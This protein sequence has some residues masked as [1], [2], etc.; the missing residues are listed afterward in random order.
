MA[1]LIQA[2]DLVL[3]ERVGPDHVRFG[4]VILFGRGEEKVIHRVVGRR[5]RQGG[6]VFFQKGDLHAPLGLV[7]APEVLGRVSAVQ[8]SGIAVD[9]TSG[10]GRVVQLGLAC[11]SVGVW[12]TKRAVGGVLAVLGLPYHHLRLGLALDGLVTAVQNRMV[13]TLGL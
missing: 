9:I 1:P 11:T 8:K 10:W 12:R 4:D 13:R 2:G 7:R 5:Q 6:L 3:L